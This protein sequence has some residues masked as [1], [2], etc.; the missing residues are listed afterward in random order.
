M[1]VF[2][3]VISRLILDFLNIDEQHYVSN[4][5]R[6]IANVCEFS[7]QHGYLKLLKWAR[8]Q[9]CDWDA[10]IC[11]WAAKNGHSEL[12]EWAISQ[13]CPQF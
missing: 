3:T 4:T 9:G 10:T 2:P 5:W 11:F 6:S 1:D 8:S 7:A 12:L 13:G